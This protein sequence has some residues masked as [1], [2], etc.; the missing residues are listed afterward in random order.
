MYLPGG[1]KEVE[2]TWI[3]GALL[4]RTG[5]EAQPVDAVAGRDRLGPIPQLSRRAQQ[6][7]N[8]L[9]CGVVNRPGFFGLLVPRGNDPPTAR[10][11]PPHRG[12][13]PP[14]SLDRTV[15]SALR[16]DSAGLP[17]RSL[18]RP[19]P[20][21]VAPPHQPHARRTLPGNTK[22]GAT[23]PST[24]RTG[25]VLVSLFLCSVFGAV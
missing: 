1:T 11:H 21:A 6:D 10:P 18:R 23:R 13:G 16:L 22:A 25:V 14:Q 5:R 24:S 12:N 8:F 7:R 20:P 3:P 4:V 9:R 15:S 17:R 2:V 19:N